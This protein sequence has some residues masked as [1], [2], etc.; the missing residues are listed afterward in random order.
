MLQGNFAG[1]A[2]RE[3]EISREMEEL[4]KAVMHLRDVSGSVSERLVPILRSEPP[5]VGT[6]APAPI[7]Q[8]PLAQ[9][10]KEQRESVAASASIFQ[11]ILRRLEL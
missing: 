7:V 3:S 8:A 11:D 1:E 9:S 2:R 5:S 10:I 4:R 6:Q